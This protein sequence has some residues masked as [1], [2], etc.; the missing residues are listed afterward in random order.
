MLRVQYRLKQLDVAEI[1]D[2]DRSTY[3]YYESGRSFPPL[4]RIITLA[5]MYSV[6]VDYLLGCDEEVTLDEKSEIIAPLAGNKKTLPVYYRLLSITDYNRGR[7]L[8]AR[9]LV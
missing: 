2:I 6:S 3:S 8:K 4:N 1:L 5:K 9:R 7:R